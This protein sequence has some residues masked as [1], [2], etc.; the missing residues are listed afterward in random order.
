VKRFIQ[1]WL[2]IDGLKKGHE[3]LRSDVEDLGKASEL[4]IRNEEK[5]K[6]T[7]RARKLQKNFEQQALME[8]KAAFKVLKGGR[9]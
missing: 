3:S 9:P 1:R 4:L 6:R 7:K 8:P 2:E 5:K